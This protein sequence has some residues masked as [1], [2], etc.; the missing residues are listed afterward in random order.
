MIADNNVMAGRGDRPVAPI[1]R[2]TMARLTRKTPPSARVGAGPRACPSAS[3]PT[4]TDRIQGRR[5]F[6]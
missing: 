3:V 4:A 2:R 6:S 5:A 1:K